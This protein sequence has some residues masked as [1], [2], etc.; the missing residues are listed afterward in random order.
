MY[1]IQVHVTTPQQRRDVHPLLDQKRASVYDAGPTM[2]QHWM[3][4]SCLLGAALRRWPVIDPTMDER[5]VF[6]GSS[7]FSF[8][9]DPLR[10][11]PSFFLVVCDAY[12]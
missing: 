7:S 1:K 5:L 6:A 12:T 3:N 11:L 9:A 8:Q 10:L 2:I 4:V